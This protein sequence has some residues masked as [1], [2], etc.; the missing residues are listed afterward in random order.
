MFPPLSGTGAPEMVAKALLRPKKYWESLTPVTI[1]NSE[2]R[3][4]VWVSTVAV[5]DGTDQ[6]G[7][8][9]SQ[10]ASAAEE[11]AE[12]VAYVEETEKMNESVTCVSSVGNIVPRGVK[13][14]STSAEVSLSTSRVDNQVPHS[15]SETPP[16]RSVEDQYQ[17]FDGVSGRH[18]KAR[19][20]HLDA[21]PEV[22]A[23][24]NLEELSIKDFLVEFK[25]GEIARWC[26]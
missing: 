19:V 10:A 6:A 23:L 15:E 18:V 13:K 16:A 17:V 20:V 21:L 4:A 11:S 22:P 9:D 26:S 14:T 1:P 12:G 25:A 24:L 7:N 3:R 8:I 2:S 5:P